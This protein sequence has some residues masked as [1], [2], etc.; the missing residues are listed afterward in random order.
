MVILI[1]NLFFSQQ[2]KFYSAFVAACGAAGAI[3]HLYVR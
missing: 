1:L 2:Q 3:A